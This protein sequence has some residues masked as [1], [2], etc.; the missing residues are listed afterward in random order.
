MDKTMKKWAITA[1]IMKLRGLGF[2]QEEIA[3]RLKIK[4]GVVQYKLRQLKKR[5][6]EKGIDTVFFEQLVELYVPKVMETLDH[7]FQR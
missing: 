6:E 1:E 3:K 7:I 4:Q 5:A 2:S